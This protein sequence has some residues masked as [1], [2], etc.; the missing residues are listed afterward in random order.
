ML[1]IAGLV[2][3]AARAFA[4]MAVAGAV[5][6]VLCG[7]G[8]L[9]FDCRYWLAFAAVIWLFYIN[10]AIRRQGSFKSPEN[11]VERGYRNFMRAGAVAGTGLAL[12]LSFSLAP[13]IGG[14][15]AGPPAS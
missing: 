4:G 10:I 2:I 1:F 5:I 9:P 13:W 7:L 14:L 8:L 11:D 12:L 3:S 15:F 6:A